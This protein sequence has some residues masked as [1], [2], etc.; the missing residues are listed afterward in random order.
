MCWLQDLFPE[1]LA[2]EH[3]LPRGVYRP[4]LVLRNAA[5]RRAWARV[6]IGQGMAKRLRA[7]IPDQPIAVIPNWAD[8]A[9]ISRLMPPASA[10]REAWALQ[11][12]FVVMYSGNLGRVHEEQ[13]MLAAAQA[14]AY[15]SGVVFLVVGG[16]VKNTRLRTEVARLELGN[17]R[18]QPYQPVARLSESLACGDVH[19]VS[20][21]PQF[22]DLVVPSKLYGVLAAGRPVLNVGSPQGAVAQVLKEQACGVTVIPGDVQG[23]IA[24][25]VHWRAHPL[26]VL[27][28]GAR[29][30]ALFEAEYDRPLMV[31][32]WLSLLS[33]LESDAS[34]PRVSARGQ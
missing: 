34:R 27:T 18:F 2:Q 16:G 12:K 6:A 5:L 23:F 14:L 30:R 19:W 17:V 1:I 28:M 8:S 11:D 4:L 31:A 9:V 10:L 32:R 7:I 21:T 3:L 15:D 24:H 20:L 26:E 13:T 25:I 29:A 22:E 33:P